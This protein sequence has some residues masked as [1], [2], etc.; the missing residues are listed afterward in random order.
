MDQKFVLTRPINLRDH[1]VYGCKL[2][3]I[4]QIIKD[5]VSGF[6]EGEGQNHTE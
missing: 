4:G 2:V 1:W 5:E 3:H 6:V